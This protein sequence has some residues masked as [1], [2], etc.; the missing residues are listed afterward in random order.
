M[1][2]ETGKRGVVLDTGGT[3]SGAS[4]DASDSIGYTAGKSGWRNSG[5]V[6]GYRGTRWGSRKDQQEH[7]VQRVTEVEQQRRAAGECHLAR[8][9]A[10]GK[11]HFHPIGKHAGVRL[12]SRVVRADTEMQDMLGLQRGRILPRCGF[13]TALRVGRGGI[14]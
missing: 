1:V 5:G 7:M 12:D 4:L 6:A 11:V 13:S 10:G 3:I 9:A 8:R 2:T 14:R